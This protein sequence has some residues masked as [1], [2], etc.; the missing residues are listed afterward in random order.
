[1]SGTRYIPVPDWENHHPWPSESGLRWLIFN[2]KKNGFDSVVRR[3]GRRILI[4]EDAF[5]DWMENC[6]Y[7]PELKDSKGSK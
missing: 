1:M 2:A 3:I 7:T 4:N 5:F 6:G